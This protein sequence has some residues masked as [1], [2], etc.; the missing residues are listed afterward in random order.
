MLFHTL[1]PKTI[2]KNL[3]TGPDGLSEKEVGKRLAKNGPNSLPHK[4]IPGKGAIFVSQFKNPLVYILIIAGVVSVLLKKYTDAG[5]IMSAVLI[6]A[7]IG[8]FQENKANDTLKKL[9]EV[10]LHEALVIRD[11]KEIKVLSDNLVIG[12]ILVLKSGNK[13]PADA[14]IFSAQDLSVN[15]A[16]LTGESTPVAKSLEKMSAGATIADQKNMVFAGTTAVRGT[17]LAI[18]CATG[19]STQ[20]G[21]I[22]QMV[23]ETPDEAT[24]LQ[25]KIAHFS[26]ILAIFFSFVAILVFAIGLLYGRSLA[27]ML[28]VSISLAVASIPEGLIIAV[29]VIL[30]LG[31]RAILNEKS[32]VRKLVATETLGS[33]TVICTDKTGTITEGKMHLVHIVAGNEQW[34]LKDKLN[35]S[36]VQ[37]IFLALKSAFLCNDA[38]IENPDDELGEWRINGTPTDTAIFSAGLQSG[39]EASLLKQELKIAELP[40]TSEKKF[41]AI[42][43]QTGKTY[44]L[45]EKGA[46]EKLLA[47][48]SKFYSNGDVKDLTVAELVKLQ[49]I[50]KN[51][52]S[53]GLRVLGVAIREKISQKLFEDVQNP[54]W[55]KIDEKLSFIGFLAIKDPL[56]PEIKETI[57]SCLI[58]GIRPV[59]ITGDHKLTAKAIARE[60][61]LSAS[62][63][64]I[65]TG[66]ELDKMKDKDLLKKIDN[67][68][69]FARVSPHHKLRIV[70]LLQSKGE[71]VAMTGDGIN[72]SP[73]L[74]AADIGIALGDGT[75]IAKES[76]DLILLDNNF[77]TIVM[78]IKRG[79]IIFSNIRKVI[80]YL[81]SDSF[82]E[83][84]LIAGSIAFGLPLALLPVQILWINIINDALPN[85]ALA[86]EKGEKGIMEEKPLA[87]NEPIL[88]K[89]MKVIIFA[90]GITRDLV[91]FALYGYLL[92]IDHNIDHIRTMIFTILAVDS[93]MYIFTLRDFKKPVWTI[94]PFSN[95][96][97]IWAVFGS[98]SL[99]LLSMYF[100]PIAAV[101][102]IV[103]LGLND[104]GIV[105]SLGLLTILMIES[106]KYRFRKI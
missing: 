37:T 36:R 7:I 65:L 75:D 90:A 89:E 59:I 64:N 99:L 63:Q 16:S 67:I 92:R 27:E 88:N 40:F 43:R 31:M 55:R 12:D 62:E 26:K 23:S 80:T 61:G 78:A 60:A 87:K 39:L 83:V 17:G 81:I 45:Y 51:L 13:I 24:P 30:V 105:F 95:P 42:L 6:N 103:P 98:F 68:T 11:G 96:V 48:C 97:L 3:K 2:F 70:R 10:I 29:T 1:L 38:N 58:A 44:T 54:N 46:P 66:E 74:K 77:A 14:R 33:T 41:M 35:P 50:Q 25:I 5:V 28:L 47:K 79:R 86:F 73:A 49:K 69:V 100:A 104:W 19:Q 21:Q 101:L 71:S 56:R 82:S 18:I 85:F 93:L 72:D 15:E 8:F 9:R 53:K 76:S 22:A 106:V 84:I 94:N 91:I 20:I 102:H 4:K 32:L 52:T 34:S 57:K